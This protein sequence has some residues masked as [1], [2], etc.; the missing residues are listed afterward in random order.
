MASILLHTLSSRMNTSLPLRWFSLMARQASGAFVYFL[1]VLLRHP[2]DYRNC[3][4]EPL[5]GS[6]VPQGIKLRF[7]VQRSRNRMST[8]P[9]GPHSDQGIPDMHSLEPD[10]AVF[11]RCW[12]SVCFPPAVKARIIF[13]RVFGSNIHF[14]NEA[15]LSGNA[16]EANFSDTLRSFAARGFGVPAA[17]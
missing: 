7:P 11:A 10:V 4:S 16:G 5:T 3:A 14:V 1:L 15:A 6:V 13:A 9:T 12:V 17:A 8:L 2:V